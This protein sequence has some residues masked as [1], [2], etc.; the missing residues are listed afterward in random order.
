MGRD[1]YRPAIVALARGG[2]VL[3]QLLTVSPQLTPEEEKARRRAAKPRIAL[4]VPQ[5][6]H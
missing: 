5:E 4:G 2:T 3:P 6:R 1:D